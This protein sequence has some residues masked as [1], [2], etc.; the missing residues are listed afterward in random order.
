MTT[1]NGSNMVCAGK[2]MGELTRLPCA[3]HTLQL[4]VG[5]GLLPAEVLIARAKR[6]INFFTTPKQT[7]KLLEIQKSTYCSNNEA[8]KLL[9][10]N[11]NLDKNYE[12]LRIIADVETC[13]NSSYLAWKRL[14]KI[15]DLIDV[16][17]STL[18]IDPNTR[19]DG[20]RLK[21][22]NLTDD[23]WQ[24]M[25][26]LVNILEDFAGATE[27]LGGSNYTT[28]SLMYS[29]LA[30][31]SN[32]MIPDD[33]NVEVIDLTSPNTA[34][35]DDVGY[36]DAPED[37]ITQQPKR[38][39]ININTP[40]NCF[41]LEKR[42]KAALYQ[43]INHYWEVP[44][45]QGML[46][47]LLDPR[48]KDLEFASETLRLQT[49]EQLKDAY[50]NMKIL[51][52]ESQE[53]ESRPTSSN[54]LL[55]RMFKNSHTYVDEVTNY[56]ALP[57]IHLDDCPLLWWKT[58]KARFP[59]LSKLARKY[60]A[61]PATSTP[62]ERLFSEAGNVVT[63]KRTQ[64]LPNTLENLVFCKKNWRLVGGVFPLSNTSE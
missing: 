10:F 16:L 13:W 55:A 63:I 20:K 49:H 25:N 36:E 48:F 6:L 47:A 8:S 39:K 28:I 9:K 61:I 38:R 40:Q 4:V 53:A 2:L 15:K 45:E 43:S 50:K 18:M 14:L 52:N 32:K 12:Y 56:L 29:L 57:K 24:A 59:I 5:K 42:V 33:S 3:A 54:S 23:E 58:N 21:D 44:Q 7:E 30:V 41:E 26:K 31:I 17:A 60:L 1:D 46:A 51:T 37:E 64:L 62:S 35:D 11:L 27:Y 22:I 19:R 34:F